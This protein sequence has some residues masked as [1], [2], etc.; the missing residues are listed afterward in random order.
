VI[1]SP[2]CRWPA[3]LN[4]KGASS[5]PAPDIYYLGYLYTWHTLCVIVLLAV[6]GLALWASVLVSKVASGGVLPQGK[7]F[8]SKWSLALKDNPAVFHEYIK[9]E[10]SLVMARTRLVGVIHAPNKSDRNEINWP[11]AKFDFAPARIDLAIRHSHSYFLAVIFPWENYI[12]KTR[13]L[14]LG[15]VFADS[16]LYCSQIFTHSSWRQDWSYRNILGRGLTD[17]LGNKSEPYIHSFLAVIGHRRG[18]EHVNINPRPRSQ[19]KLLGGGVSSTGGGL[20][21]GL[22]GLGSIF[23]LAPL[24]RG[25]TGIKEQTDKPDDLHPKLDLG[26]VLFDIRFEDSHPLKKLFHVL[27]SVFCAVAFVVIGL[28]IIH[29]MVPRSDPAQGAMGLGCLGLAFIF[30]GFLCVLLVC[31]LVSQSWVANNNFWKRN[32]N[33]CV[34]SDYRVM[35]GV[36]VK[37]AIPNTTDCMEYGWNQNHWGMI[38]KALCGDLLIRKFKLSVS[39]WEERVRHSLL[40]VPFDLLSLPVAELLIDSWALIKVC[41]NLYECETHVERRGRAVVLQSGIR[42]KSRAG[43]FVSFENSLTGYARDGDSDPWTSLRR[44]STSRSVSR[45]PISFVDFYGVSRIDGKGDQGYERDNVANAFA[46]FEFLPDRDDADANSPYSF[47]K[48]VVGVPCF[49]LGI[50]SLGVLLIHYRLTWKRF[51]LCSSI[52]ALG[53]V[54]MHN[55]LKA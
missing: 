49:A 12:L 39:A 37:S 9:S 24:K 43:H 10:A 2:H 28:A 16:L 6:T 15:K 23:H 25:N 11:L 30:L 53:I 36:A 29:G 20:S 27:V 26:A 22:T 44:Q 46:N 34:V 4:K 40:R 31:I 41:P 3:R 21:C 7:G 48:F 5:S 14:V 17:V 54:L 50:F 18:D 55:F 42:R 1:A 45:F 47:F 38:N 33:V 32:C 51:F 35:N 13:I 52:A 19:F 8:G